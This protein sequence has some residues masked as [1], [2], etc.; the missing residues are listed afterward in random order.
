MSTEAP[1][2]SLTPDLMLDAV[3]SLGLICDGRFIALNSYEN[4]V[5]QM[6]LEDAQPVIAKFYRPGRWSDEAILEEHAFSAELV[7]PGRLAT[8]VVCAAEF[9]VGIDDRDRAE[10][11]AFLETIPVLPVTREVAVGAGAYRRDVRRHGI[12]IP[13]PV[14]SIDATA[15]TG[16]ATLDSANT[17]DF[18]MTDLRVPSLGGAKRGG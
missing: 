11:I 8:S 17:R 10:A 9:L 7:A 1:Y 12:T 3:E 14:A 2:A 5:Y 13:L 4:R 16:Q 18:P 6:G 15:K